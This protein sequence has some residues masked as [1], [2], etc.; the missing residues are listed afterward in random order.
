VTTETIRGLQVTPP[1]G[2]V[3]EETT[4]T[5]RVPEDQGFHDPR[6]STPVRP[7]LVV[8]RMPTAETDLARHA[9][10][11]QADLIKNIP[12]LSEIDV[13]DMR[14]ADGAEG[15][16]LAYALPA[17]KGLEV[18]QFRAM[19]LDDGTLTTLTISTEREQ[20]TPERKESYLLALGSASMA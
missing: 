15:V 13:Q 11:A 12:G 10:H 9:A 16:L 7:N 3:T 6:T 5:M 4:L 19:R 2:F 18:C 1:A 14:F 17:P 8:H 20:L